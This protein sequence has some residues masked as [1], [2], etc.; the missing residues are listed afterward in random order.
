M[1][2]ATLA[3]HIQYVDGTVDPGDVQLHIIKD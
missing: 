3:T 2:H 1:C